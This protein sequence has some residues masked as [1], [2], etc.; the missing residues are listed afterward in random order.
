MTAESSTIS[1]RF[2][3]SVFSPFVYLS[4]YYFLPTPKMNDMKNSPM[5]L[6]FI[7]LFN[8]AKGPPSGEPCLFKSVAAFPVETDRQK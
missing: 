8:R 6:Q 5:C 4:F 7:L 3:M 1:M 2:V